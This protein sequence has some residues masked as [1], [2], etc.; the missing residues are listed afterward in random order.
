MKTAPLNVITATSVTVGNAGT[1]YSQTYCSEYLSGFSA[2]FIQM[3]GSSNVTITQEGSIDGTNF[4]AVVS[5]TGGALGAVTSALTTTSGV[6]IQFAP[7]VAKYSRLKI[8]GGAAST[9]NSLFVMITEE[10]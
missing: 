4:Y 1:I 3:L 7:I 8:V 6:Y 5:S 10:N 2:V 9:I